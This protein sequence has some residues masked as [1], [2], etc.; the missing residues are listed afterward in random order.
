MAVV[1]WAAKAHWWSWWTQFHAHRG[2]CKLL[3]TSVIASH[4]NCCNAYRSLPTTECWKVKTFSTSPTEAVAK[5]CDEHVCVSVSL[6]TSISLESHVRSFFIN[7]SGHVAYGRGLVLLRQDDE[8]PRGRH[9][10]EGYPGHSNALAIFAAAM[11]AVFTAKGI[12]QSPITTCS[13]S[14]HSL[15]QEKFK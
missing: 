10:F 7:F 14:N 9:N 2:Q 13:R 5:Y 4:K 15:C 3:V 6:S 11:A 8:I 12:I 1:K